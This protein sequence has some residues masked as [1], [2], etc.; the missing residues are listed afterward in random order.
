MH[1]PEHKILTIDQG[2][3]TAKATLWSGTDPVGSLRM[4]RTNIEEL[5]PLL[6]DEGAQGAIYSSV[7]HTDAKF[8]ESLRHMLDGRLEVLTH[9]TPLPIEVHY[10]N[11]PTLGNDRV[12]A[13]AGAAALHPGQTSLIV[14]AGTAVTID[15][16]EGGRVFCG[17]NI[18]PGVWLRLDSLHRFTDRLPMVDPHGEVPDFGHD[19][20]TAIRAGVLGG[21][22]AEIAAAYAH[23]RARC[24][25]TRL[26][27]TGSDTDLLLPLLR[28]AGL[29]P[30]PQ[31]NLVGRGL[32]HIFSL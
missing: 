12:A 31:P 4:F 26:V 8:L 23:A 15:L 3:T 5:L 25:D 7:G 14:D 24:G 16:L 11:R 17:G 22:V 27:I 1:N 32:L 29:D 28:N 10:G 19:T 9:A 18:A 21:M 30:D 13:A 2:N 20:V 6:G